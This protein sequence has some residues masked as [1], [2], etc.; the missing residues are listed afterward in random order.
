MKMPR[1]TRNNGWWPSGAWLG[2]LALAVWLG[3]RVDGHAGILLYEFAGIHRSVPDNDPS[4]LTDV[5]TPAA[6]ST[7]EAGMIITDVN[8]HLSLSGASAVNGDLYVYLQHGDSVAVLLNRVGRTMDNS[9]GYGDPGFDVTL[10]DQAPNGDIHSYRSTLFG[11]DSVPLGGPLTDSIYG[12]WAPDARRDDPSV[13]TLENTARRD[14]AL[15]R[16]NGSVIGGDWTL[17]V[18]DINGGGEVTLDHWSL[19]IIAVPEPA[20]WFPAALVALAA[21]WTTTAINRTRSKRLPPPWP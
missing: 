12:P 1:P 13:V 10:D 11:N 20:G 16:F 21:L 7:V 17:F 6:T 8:V 3:C 9:S 19:E 14:A 4:G 18:A 2:W 5:R 15:S